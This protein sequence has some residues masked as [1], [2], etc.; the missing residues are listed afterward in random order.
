MSGIT[1][2]ARDTRA[3]VL[4]DEGAC[5]AE[6]T[7]GGFD[8]LA[9]TPWAP[10]VRPAPVPADDEATWVARWR[11]GWHLC[12]PTAG[13]SD[14][15]ARPIQGFHGV[16]SQG[17]WTVEH[18][19]DTGVGLGWADTAGLSAARH[20]T[21][22]PGMLS[23]VTTASNSGRVPRQIIVAEHLILGQ[24][25]LA[26]ASEGDGRL[27]VEAS[28]TLA[29]LDYDGTPTGR[30]TAWP[31]DGWDRV[32]R[33]TPPRVAALQHPSP[34]VIAVTGPRLRVTVSWEGLSHA[35]LWEE[36]GASSGSPW[37]GAVFALGIEPTSTPHGA[38]TAHTVGAIM[39]D[40]GE[41]MTWATRLEVH[42]VEISTPTER[43]LR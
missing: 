28:G 25:V 32:S 17:T 31:G 20:W 29:E 14:P 40:P 38:G 37:N 3:L 33:R 19:D 41:S 5:A 34:R 8:V 16:A 15:D 35:L 42:P 12:F 26:Q 22:D 27:E 11:G 30:L 7:V 6:L 10:S 4:P 2:R 1:L 39:L 24:D 18:V 23:V 13:A 9:R 43:E 21:V 36:I